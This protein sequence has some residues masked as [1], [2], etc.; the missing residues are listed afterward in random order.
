MHSDAPPNTVFNK[1][2]KPDTQCL[3]QVIKVNFNRCQSAQ[4]HVP[5]LGGEEDD[6]FPLWSSSS[7]HIIPSRIMRKHQT[8]PNG[9]AAKYLT[10]APQNCHNHQRQVG[11]TST[12]QRNRRRPDD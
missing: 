6:P 9:H 4:E 11:E 12:V 5:L 1:V 2:E 3:S 8:N 7:K 10:S